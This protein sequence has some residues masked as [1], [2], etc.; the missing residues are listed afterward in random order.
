MREGKRKKSIMSSKVIMIIIRRAL[1]LMDLS[2][3]KNTKTY[4]CVSVCVF[5]W[6]NV[7]DLMAKR[8]QRFPFLN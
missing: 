2:A 7:T 1:V 8:T 6:G 5:V 3:K 4:T